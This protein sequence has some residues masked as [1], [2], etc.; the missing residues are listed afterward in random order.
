MTL[1]HEAAANGN[2]AFIRKLTDALQHDSGIKNGPLHR[3]D[4]IIDRLFARP[5]PVGT[6]KC[7]AEASDPQSTL[8]QLVNAYDEHGMTALHLAVFHGHFEATQLLLHLGA[9]INAPT[10]TGVSQEAAYGN[11]A[12]RTAFWSFAL[13]LATS[14]GHCGIVKL[15]LANGADPYLL[16]CRGVTARDLALRNE[17]PKCADAITKHLQ[18][19][20]ASAATSDAIIQGFAP[21]KRVNSESSLPLYSSPNLSEREG[22]DLDVPPG[23]WDHDDLFFDK[24]DVDE[25][26]E[27]HGLARH[28]SAHIPWHR[29]TSRREN[30]A[31]HNTIN[32][33]R[34]I[35][36]LDDELLF[37]IN[38]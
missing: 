9:L 17:Q 33:A 5:Q 4:S 37:G 29:R 10:I 23:P 21:I 25:R 35:G 24:A 2:T 31:S 36:E 20:K 30:R 32:S 16:D 18:S 19:K 26:E 22:G 34:P 27:A 11:D 3:R 15:L 8:Y 28:F 1:L 6:V 12:S 13:H 38:E 14:R 7:C